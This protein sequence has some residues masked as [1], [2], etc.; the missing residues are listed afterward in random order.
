MLYLTRPRD[1]EL[2]KEIHENGILASLEKIWLVCVCIVGG[3]FQP[4]TVLLLLKR[5][6]WS[7]AMKFSR[8][9]YTPWIFNPPTCHEICTCHKGNHTHSC[10]SLP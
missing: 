9:L 1:L 5:S 7:V 4:L 2:A 8:T 10:A 3:Y 6:T